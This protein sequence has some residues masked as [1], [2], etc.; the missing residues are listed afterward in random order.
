MVL[1]SLPESKGKGPEAL[2]NASKID[3]GTVARLTAYRDIGLLSPGGFP[4]LLKDAEKYGEVEFAALTLGLLL[5]KPE[6]SK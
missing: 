5:A 2:E 4:A 1:A 6:K 3:K